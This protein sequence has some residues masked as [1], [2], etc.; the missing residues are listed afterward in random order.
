MK[1]TSAK[2]KCLVYTCEISTSEENASAHRGEICTS[3]IK[4]K[5]KTFPFSTGGPDI[6][7]DYNNFSR[8]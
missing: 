2:L 6:E 8:L 3:I 1:S 7:Y 5:K 4:H